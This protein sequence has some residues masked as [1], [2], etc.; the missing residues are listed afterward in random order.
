[1]KLNKNLTVLELLER[2]AGRASD[3]VAMVPPPS[4][5]P[6]F[7]LGI[8]NGEFQISKGPKPMTVNGVVDVAMPKLGSRKVPISAGYILADGHHGEKRL[9]LY[10]HGLN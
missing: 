1:M 7:F 6:E 9:H 5:K 4:S 2:A 8:S 10:T 3:P